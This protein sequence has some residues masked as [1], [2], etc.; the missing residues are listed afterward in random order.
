MQNDLS[1]QNIHHTDFN[2]YIDIEI[3][4]KTNI[5]YHVSISCAII[6]SVDM[7]NLVIYLKNYTKCRVFKSL[8]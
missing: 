2:D 5:D 6:I 7:E 1:S 3:D 8:L 4:I